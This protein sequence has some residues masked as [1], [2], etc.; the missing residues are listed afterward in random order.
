MSLAGSSDAAAAAAEATIARWHSYPVHQPAPYLPLATARAAVTSDKLLSASSMARAPDR[1]VRGCRQRWKGMTLRTRL[2]MIA[3]KDTGKR[4]VWI[5]GQIGDQY[6][7]STVFETYERQQEFLARTA[8]GVGKT[9]G[10]AKATPL[11]EVAE[12]VLVWFH[13]VSARGKTRVPMFLALESPRRNQ[14]SAR[15]GTP[16]ICTSPV[17]LSKIAFGQWRVALR[18]WLR[19]GISGF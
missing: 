13:A 9:S 15:A 3:R 11:E 7:Q 5:F 6:A 18:T 10:A 16:T 17:G 14:T 12:R 4:W 8:G 2:P 19:S 1:C